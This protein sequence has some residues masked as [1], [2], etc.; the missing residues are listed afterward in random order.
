MKRSLAVSFVLLVIAVLWLVLFLFRPFLSYPSPV[1]LTCLDPEAGTIESLG[2]PHR[3]FGLGLSY[4]GH[5]AESPGLYDP[6]SGPPVFKKR[7]RSVNRSDRI[8][9]PSRE[10]LL[11]AASRVDPRHA[12]ALA[13]QIDEIPALLDY[14]VEVGL[15]V[16]ESFPVANLARPD[17]V[18]PL[19][20]FVANDITARILIGMAPEYDLTVRYLAEGKGLAGFLPVGDHVFVPADP[21]PDSWL[22]VELVTEVNGKVRQRSS[23][24]DIIYSPRQILES[25]ARG[26]GLDSFDAG[27]WIITGTPPGVALQTAGWLQRALLLVDPSAQTKVSVMAGSEQEGSAFL[28]PGDGVR[29]SAGFLGHK[30][31]RVVR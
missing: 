1:Q 13:E 8:P 20:Y 30:T 15:V 18:P 12:A 14:E 2:P 31:S 28:H 24:T 23:S 9:Y 17:F 27:D 22:C 26:E 7:L 4:A 21:G 3:V 19:G 29:V 10:D 11:E 5:I 16:F 6:D 25:V